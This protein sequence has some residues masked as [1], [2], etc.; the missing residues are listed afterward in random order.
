MSYFKLSESLGCVEL[1]LASLVLSCMSYFKLHDLRESC[2][3]CVQLITQ[4]VTVSDS[5]IESVE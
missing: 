3:S 1:Q 2:V 5:P 4:I